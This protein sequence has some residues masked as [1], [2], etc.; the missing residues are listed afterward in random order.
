MRDL[1]AAT[2]LVADRFTRWCERVV[3]R[4]PWGLDRIVA[5]TFLGFALLNSFTFGVDLVLLTLFRSGFG[6]PVP[7]SFT[8]AYVCAFSLA[9]VLNRT[10]NFHS[11]AP[12]GRQAV[13]YAVVVAINYAAFILGVGGGLAALGV[14]YHLARL[15]AG[16][17]EAIYMY[18]CMRWVVFRKR[19]PYR[20]PVGDRA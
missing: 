6:W 8:V 20:E 5:P 12:V 19:A 2:E 18:S 3:A 7:L 4:L 16:G 13:V 11:H 10:F 1:T 17:C 15:V 9:F 14:P